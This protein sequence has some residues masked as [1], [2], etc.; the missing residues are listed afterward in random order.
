MLS[1]CDFV[2]GLFADNLRLLSVEDFLGVIGGAEI[3]VV[4]WIA[5]VDSFGNEEEDG[6][7]EDTVEDGAD[8]VRPVPAEILCNS[9]IGI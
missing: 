8:A 7:D 4:G 3:E 5:L 2:L 6:E 1:L 9:Q